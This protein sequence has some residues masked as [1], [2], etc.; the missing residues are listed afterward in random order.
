MKWQEI[1][2]GGSYRDARGT[3]R[4]VVDIESDPELRDNEQYRRVLH[5][6]LVSGPPRKDPRGRSLLEKGSWS[7]L[8]FAQWARAEVDPG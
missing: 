4:K 5:W 8:R 7:W 2:R 3:I 1:Q 6:V